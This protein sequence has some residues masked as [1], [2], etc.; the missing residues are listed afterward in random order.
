M[1]WGRP[2]GGD[3]PQGGRAT[4]RGRGE[5]RTANGGGGEVTGHNVKKDI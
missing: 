4:R 1:M 2:V 3:N 5:R